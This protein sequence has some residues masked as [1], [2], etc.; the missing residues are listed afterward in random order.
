[1]RKLLLGLSAAALLAGFAAA[2]SPQAPRFD[3]LIQGG[4][5]VDGTGAPYIVADVAV[6]GGRIAAVGRL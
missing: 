1:M 5:V 4:R 6:I 3:L 2:H